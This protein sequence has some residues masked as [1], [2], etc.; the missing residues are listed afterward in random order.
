MVCICWREFAAFCREILNYICPA[1][2]LVRGAVINNRGRNQSRKRASCRPKLKTML[3]FLFISVE[4]SDVSEN[5]AERT[6]SGLFEAF[7]H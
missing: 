6:V 7:L 1:E 5:P 2:R 4:R 3:L